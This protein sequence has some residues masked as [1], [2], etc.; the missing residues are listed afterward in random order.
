MNFE[1]LALSHHGVLIFIEIA[2]S[3]KTEIQ[4]NLLD[5]F[6]YDFFIFSFLEIKIKGK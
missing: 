6:H 5:H 4:Q 2:E 1:T 3:P